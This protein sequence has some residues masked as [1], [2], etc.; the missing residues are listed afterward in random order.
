VGLE[1]RRDV[2][3]PR[4][5]KRAQRL[6]VRGLTETE[7]WAN[8]EPVVGPALGQPPSTS[9]SRLAQSGQ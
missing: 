6:C 1:V 3:R 4:P 9:N 2:P 5:V 7:P 8:L